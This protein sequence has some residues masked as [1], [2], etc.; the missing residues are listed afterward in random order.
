MEGFD[1]HEKQ[2][3]TLF[4]LSINPTE[5]LSLSGLLKEDVLKYLGL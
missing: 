4:F 5:L 2:G 1:N 3:A